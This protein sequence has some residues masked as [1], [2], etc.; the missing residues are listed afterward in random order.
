MSSQLLT[1]WSDYQLSIDAVLALATRT[2]SIFDAD[3]S[4]LKLED[5][6]RHARLRRLLLN[7]EYACRLTIIV[8]C[9][10][11]VRQHCPR[12]LQLLSLYGSALSIIEAPSS[13]ASLQDSLLIADE[14]HLLVR[15]DRQQPRARRMVDTA[16]DCAPY[17][18][19]FAEIF[20]EGGQA[21][22]PTTLGL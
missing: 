6:A 1:T 17:V 18:A 5:P 22:S 10:D 11:F 2:L 14:R 8:Q 20:A 7:R 21:I 13:L 3:L 12:L 16:D 9:A 19:R 15:F 4:L